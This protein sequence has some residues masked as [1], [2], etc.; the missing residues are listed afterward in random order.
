MITFKTIKIDS[1]GFPSMKF[2]ETILSSGGD[3][4][5]A[6]ADPLKKFDQ[7]VHPHFRKAMDKLKPHFVVMLEDVKAINS[8]AQIA[9]ELLEDYIIYGF[10]R[11][12]NPEMPG[13]TIVGAKKLSDGSINGRNTTFKRFYEDA[14]T[15]NAYPF[16]Q[17]LQTILTGIDF[18]GEEFMSGKFK[19]E[20]QQELPFGEPNGDKSK[21]TVEV[22]EAEEG[23][24]FEG[25]KPK[26]GRKKKEV[27]T[28]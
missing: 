7:P 23:S 2:K 26:R 24:V 11:G 8:L 3:N 13:I 14:G 1:D 4:K 18:E 27:V 16:Q 6:H 25:D 21:T 15:E 17:H 9:P 10:H 28:E 5:A 19:P 20:E 12:S 22:L